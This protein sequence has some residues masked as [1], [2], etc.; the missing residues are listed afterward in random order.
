[1]SPLHANL[2]L[3]VNNQLGESPI[4]DNETQTY[5]WV[6]ILDRK[7]YQFAQIGQYIS[8]GTKKM[9][10][11]VN[12]THS[13]KLVLTLENEVVLFDPQTEKFDA[14]AKIPHSNR[15]LRAN[16]CQVDPFGRL[17]VGTMDMKESDK[18]GSLYLL[19]KDNG[20][21]EVLTG[22]TVSNGLC[23]S[24]DQNKM[25]YIDSPT[26]SVQVFYFDDTAHLSENFEKRITFPASM[27]FPDGMCIDREGDLYVAFWGGNCVAVIDPES[28]GIKEK[29]IVPA[30]HVT[31]CCF[32]GPEMDQLFITTARE[33]LS[34]KQ[35]ETFPLSGS[36]FRYK[37]NSRGLEK[38]RF[39]PMK[40]NNGTDTKS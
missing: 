37:T 39:K 26:R 21:T 40:E 22:I 16:D 17:W 36:I 29:I 8:W 6:D 14:V 31:S 25:Y 24:P 27:G 23:W 7:F 2:F 33:G 13:D 20:F 32:G 4:W 34:K 15:H 30:P 11:S 38:Y 9:V 1:M 19:N 35:L 28:G 18:N 3:P 5:Y 10:S 12:L